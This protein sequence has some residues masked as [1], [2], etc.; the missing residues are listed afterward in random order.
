MTLDL[1]VRVLV[2]A[3]ITVLSYKQWVIC[4]SSDGSLG[5]GHGSLASTHCLSVD[6]Y[7]DLSS[8]S[9]FSTLTFVLPGRQSGSSM[10]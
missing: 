10:D 3:I 7:F 6:Q 4:H 5:P 2:Y 1:F 9:T 8:Y